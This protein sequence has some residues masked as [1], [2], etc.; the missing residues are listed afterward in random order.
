MGLILAVKR[1][2][3]YLLP[4]PILS[5]RRFAR[6]WYAAMFYYA[7]GLFTG[8]YVR[9]ADSAGITYAFLAVLCCLGIVKWWSGASANPPEG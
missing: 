1:S 2:Y 3:R 4:R 9:P 8:M 7:V 5:P 6:R